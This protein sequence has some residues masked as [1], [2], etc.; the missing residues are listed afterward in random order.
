MLDLAYADGQARVRLNDGMGGLADET[1]S[2]DQREAISVAPLDYGS[3]QR[4]DLVAQN[5]TVNAVVYV[6]SSAGDELHDAVLP[7]QTH[8]TR[9]LLTGQIDAS[10]PDEVIGYTPLEGWLLVELWAGAGGIPQ[11]SSLAGDDALAAMGDFNGDGADDLVA[12]G[13][14]SISY[15]QGGTNLD[16]LPILVCRSFHLTRGPTST[17][18]VGDFDG[19]GRADVAIDDGGNPR[20]LL[21][22]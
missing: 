13:A 19:N 5:R 11:R 4:N 21:S 18:A 10:A 3:G 15:V 12:A 1:I 14:A 6:G 16:S 17:L 7:G 8:G 2:L 22:Q 9:R 20:V